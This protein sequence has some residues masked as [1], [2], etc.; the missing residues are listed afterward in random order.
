MTDYQHP[1][2]TPA[3]PLATAREFAAE[4]AELAEQFEPSDASRY[5][6]QRDGERF[7]DPYQHPAAIR[8]LETAIV[9]IAREFE[10]SVT[11]IAGQQLLAEALI[12]VR[13]RRTAA[14][15]RDER[16]YGGAVDR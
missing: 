14:I 15:D 2:T 8:W 10:D 5:I 13:A 16:L 12:F 3:D 6:G 4:V 1:P 11:T 7:S 9:R